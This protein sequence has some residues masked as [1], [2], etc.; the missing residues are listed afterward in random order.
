[1]KRTK[2]AAFWRALLGIATEMAMAV[3][4][5]ACALGISWLFSR[6]WQ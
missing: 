4:I 3:F 1:M 2:P 6:G 5:M